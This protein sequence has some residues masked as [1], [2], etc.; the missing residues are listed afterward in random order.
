MKITSNTKTASGITRPV[1]GQFQS[2]GTARSHAKDLNSRFGRGHR[3]LKA[4][5]GRTFA[6]VF[7]PVVAAN[8]QR[9]VREVI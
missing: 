3:A 8:K 1:A 5:D 4:Q 2:F 7:R 6:I 9:K